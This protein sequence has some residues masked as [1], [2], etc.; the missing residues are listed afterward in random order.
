VGAGLPARRPGEAEAALALLSG[1]EQAWLTARRTV[2]SVA[3]RRRTSRAAAA[4]DVLA[5]V[6]LVSATSL[7]A[8]LGMAPKNATVLLDALCSVGIAVEVTHRAKRR[9]FGLAGLAPLREEVAP[10]RRPVP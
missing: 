4:V 7:A 5:A 8:A 1:L 3:G 10:P 9:L 6:P 2:A